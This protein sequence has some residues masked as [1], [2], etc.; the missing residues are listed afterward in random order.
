[1]KTLEFKPFIDFL[2][3]L[4]KSYTVSFSLRFVVKTC[5]FVVTW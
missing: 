4:V 5:D 3:P 2:A 1:M